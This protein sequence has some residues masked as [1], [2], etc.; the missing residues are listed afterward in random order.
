MRGEE[1]KKERRKR[2]EI[3]NRGKQK[4]IFWKVAGIGNK[5]RE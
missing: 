2:K 5:Y 4:I 3:K 1:G